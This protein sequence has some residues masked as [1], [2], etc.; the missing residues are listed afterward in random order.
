MGTFDYAKRN[1]TKS[2]LKVNTEKCLGDV[3]GGI[4]VFSPKKVWRVCEITKKEEKR[5]KIHY[6]DFDAKYDEW[7]PND[8]DRLRAVTDKHR[9]YSPNFDNIESFYKQIRKRYYTLEK[10]NGGEIDLHSGRY[11]Y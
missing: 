7:I 4:I 3:G 9:G 11:T 2:P 8:S 6:T 5:V 10:G 1:P